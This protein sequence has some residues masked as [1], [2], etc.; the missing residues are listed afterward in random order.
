MRFPLVPVLSA[1]VLSSCLGVAR[2][3]A[4]AAPGTSATHHAD[5]SIGLRFGTPG[6]GLE[7]GK[8]LTDHLSV[9]VGAY[10]VK[11]TATKAQSDVTYDASLKL[12][13]VSALVDLYPWRRGGFHFT[14]GIATNPMTVTGTGQPTGGTYD[15][16]GTSYTSAQV[17]TLTAVAKFPGTNPY[18]GIGFGTP[19]RSGGAVEFLFDLG[20]VI[21]QPTITLSATGAA[22]DP[23][24]LADM[25]AQV[26]QTQ[27][28]V[29]KYLKV[30]P[31][32]AFGLALRF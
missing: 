12:H 31:V 11:V 20:A 30:Y 3:G 10:Y 2:L 4:Q 8:L 22:N 17:G 15:I 18:V 7:L 21:G 28:D 24:L 13:A 19:S 32:L 29:R 16:N 1:A 9:R 25:Q 27:S 23:A 14:A 6:L 26:A 5:V